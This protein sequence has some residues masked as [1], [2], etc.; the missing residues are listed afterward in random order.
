MPANYHQT[1]QSSI[2]TAM[3]AKARL[4]AVAQHIAFS[5]PHYR[6]IS[7]NTEPR[8]KMISDL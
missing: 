2:V 5:A 7:E 1:H 6:A 3:V 4:E 8:L